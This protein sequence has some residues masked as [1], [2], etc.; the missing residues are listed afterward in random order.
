MCLTS[1]TQAWEIIEQKCSFF[2]IGGF[3][4]NPGLGRFSPFLRFPFFGL[5]A[6]LQA[7]SLLTC[8]ALGWPYVADSSFSHFALPSFWMS[9]LGTRGEMLIP[10]HCHVT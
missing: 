7:Q 10:R 1:S 2:A 8:L 3:V 9:P 5:L 4:G 6:A